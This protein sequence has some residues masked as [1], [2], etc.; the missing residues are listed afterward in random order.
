MTTMIL[1]IFSISLKIFSAQEKKQ[2]KP[3]ITKKALEVQRKKTTKTVEI[4]IAT[5]ILTSP[6]VVS[7]F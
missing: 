6:I 1:N 3:K 5:I 4:G 2:I 7:S